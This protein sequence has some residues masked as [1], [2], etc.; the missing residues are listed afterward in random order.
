MIDDPDRC[1]AALCARDPRFDGWFTF[2]VTTTGIQCRP[3]CPARTPSRGNV[4]FFA[5]SAAATRAGFRACRRCRPDA[6]PGSPGW[7]H[8]ADLVGRAVRAIA[9][10]EVDR[11]G[12]AGLADLLGYSPRHL[13]RQLTAEL[14][15]GPRELARTQ[16][17]HTARTLIEHTPMPFTEVA[18]AAGFGSL[19]QF[20]ATVR[21][22]HDA[23]PTQLRA[24]ARSRA[25]GPR[26]LDERDAALTLRLA[27]RTPFAGDALL[28]HLA[29]RAVPGLE[30]H[31]PGW[32]RRAL[33]LP[34]GGAVA[35][36]RPGPEAVVA[37]LHL[38]DPSDLAA[39]VAR[40]RRMLDLD[41]DPAAT[42]HDLGEDPA[43]GPL[44]AATPGLRCPASPDPL[45]ACLRAVVGQQVS[46][47]GAATLMARIV[48]RC[49]TPLRQPIGGITH[50]LPDAAMLAAADLT[51]LG[52]PAARAATVQRLAAALADGILDLGPG[53]DRAQDRA[54]LATMPGVGPW[55]ADVLALRG[56]RD[57]DAFPATDL[58]VRRTAASLGLPEDAVAL[59]AASRR[60]RPW[61]AH[62]AQHL[63]HHAATDPP[64][65]AAP[66][67]PAARRDLAIASATRP[68]SIP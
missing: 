68:A 30:E 39:A 7:D 22:H 24:A 48:D 25:T 56:L 66:L 11:R 59:R 2:G 3:S 42:D 18:S 34:G 54:T 12:V 49:G 21:D 43:L 33:S 37:T 9:D 44:V 27:T 51:G 23:S 16:R 36:L 19:R 28:A 35:T 47:A 62:A 57:P 65:A 14:G 38:D 58:V 32:H 41:A 20:N 40:L 15:V 61:R 50:R 31:G 6:T 17:V 10:G 13:H 53:A 26:G 46:V 64:A 45:D 55:T 29:T 63:W 67:L 60:W 52:L 4:R 8:R 1:Y 5:T